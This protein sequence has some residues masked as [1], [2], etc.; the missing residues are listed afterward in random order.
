[1]ASKALLAAFFGGLA[2]IVALRILFPG[3]VGT[4]A[5]TAVAVAA[6]ILLG[7]Y[8]HRH[9]RLADRQLVGD[10]LYYLGLLFTLASLIIALSRLFLFG[11]EGSVEG[12][13]YELIGNFGIALIATVAGILGR[14]LLQSAGEEH[15]AGGAEGGPMRTSDGPVVGGR[16]LSI[17][18]QPRRDSVRR[19]HGQ[20]VG[21][22]PLS[23]PPDPLADAMALRLALRQATDAF[24][25]F[26][27]ITT[28]QTEQTIAHTER[29]IQAFNAEMTAAASSGL[30]DTAD[31]WRETARAMQA[32]A[33][34]IAERF[35]KLTAEFSERISDSAKS[36]IEGIATAWK[37]A[38]RSVLADN[39][40]MN[41]RLK[42]NFEETV[43]RTEVARKALTELADAVTLSAQRMNAKAA[44]LASMVEAAASASRGMSSLS[45]SLEAARRSLDGLAQRA[46]DAAARVEG[47]AAEIVDAH[48]AFAQGERERREMV[49]RE[50][51]SAVSEFAESAREGLARDGERWL[52]AVKEF[53]ADSHEQQQL[54]ARNVE[55][56]RRWG[57]QMSNEVAEWTN[58]A[59][60]TRKSLVE[61][62]D[63]LTDT[64]RKS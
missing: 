11:G 57:R 43:T 36:G 5:A 49:L 48:K 39:E 21:G 61:V 8:Y 37:N 20:V 31:A 16:P 23:T 32:D 2:P 51:K 38:L 52:A 1:M 34:Q 29:T 12:R 42:G 4:V 17:P 9:D 53:A 24:S 14:V 58:L 6:I 13:A 50:Y 26:T 28:S 27:R 18:L 45:G 44:E 54:G 15:V 60:H 33:E 22:G 35:E 19:E 30:R 63:R 40:R 56:A 59:E 10:N 55:T 62:V 46:I 47:S 41:Q 64:V 25:H 7:L 3:V